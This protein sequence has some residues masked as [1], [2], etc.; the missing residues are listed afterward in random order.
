YFFSVIKEFV[1]FGETDD[2]IESQAFAEESEMARSRIEALMNALRRHLEIVVIELER[3]DDPQIIFETLNARG[4]PLLP[5]DLI[6]NFAFLEASRGGEGTDRLFTQYWLMF[7]DYDRGPAQ[8]WKSVE[9]QGRLSRP[10][11]DLFMFPY[12]TS[13]VVQ[14]VKITHLFQEFQ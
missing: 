3:G 14:E 9:R 2:E 6:R 10:R 1:I 13:K 8:F 4:V 7:D 5:S 11:I 12:L